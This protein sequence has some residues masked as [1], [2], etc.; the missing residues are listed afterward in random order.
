MATIAFPN[1]SQVVRLPSGVTYAYTYF[2]AKANNPT[3]LFIH[4]FPSSSYDWRHQVTYFS[5]LGY[6]V[7]S[8]DLLGYGETDKPAS[9]SD[10]RGKKMASEINELLE[11]VGITTVHG[12]AHDWGSFLLSRLAN[13]Y[14]HRLLTCS[15]LATPY[16]APG[17]S[18]NIDAVNEFTK[19]K[20]GYEMYGY[21]K[22][23]EKEEAAQFLKD[24]V[25]CSVRCLSFRYV[26]E[27]AIANERVDRIILINS[28][29]GRSCYLA[30]EFGAAGCGGGFCREWQ[31]RK[32]GRLHYR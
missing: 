14:P 15:F 28:L 20:L 11:H 3:I 9:L 25:C 26:G 13:Y 24:H 7:L 6:G 23:F 21:W 30:G 27:K 29:S 5:S 16:R 2:P 31:A 18:M 8:P 10:Y 22:F 32:E 4:G 12:V 1:D 19:Q 17:Q